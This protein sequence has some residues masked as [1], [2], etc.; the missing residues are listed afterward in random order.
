MPTHF[1]VPLIVVLL[2]AL[3]VVLLIPAATPQQRA[4][5]KKLR[6]ANWSASEARRAI[7]YTKLTGYPLGEARNFANQGDAK[8]VLAKQAWKKGRFDNAL[9][10]ANE[11]VNRFNEAI[12]KANSRQG[13]H[14]S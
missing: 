14:R 9:T 8:L 2:V 6:D 10:L 11:A 5:K 3:T 12:S 13:L 1:L 4:A 7:S